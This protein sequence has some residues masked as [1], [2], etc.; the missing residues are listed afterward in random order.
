MNKRSVFYGRRQCPFVFLRRSFIIFL[1]T[2][3]RKWK[4]CEH[5]DGRSD[6]PVSTWGPF[7]AVFNCVWATCGIICINERHHILSI[8]NLSRLKWKLQ[9][10]PC[11]FLRPLE[12]WLPFPAVLQGTLAYIKQTC[13]N[14][15]MAQSHLPR[16]FIIYSCFSYLVV[17]FMC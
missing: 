8:K 13:F 3:L 14:S 4:E 9:R 12:I 2:L 11:W 6:K 1:F 5:Y 15:T 10:T 7:L 17:W 16:H